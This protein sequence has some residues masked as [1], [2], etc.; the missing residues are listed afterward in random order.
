M[1]ITIRQANISDIN[2]LIAL[3][4]EL[5]EIEED[6]IFD[7]EKQRRGVEL[8]LASDN[9]YIIVAEHDSEVIA[10]CTVL[11][12]ISTAEG[13]HVG[14]IEDMVVQ[15][16]YACKGIGRQLLSA[17]ELRAKEQGLTR[18]QLLADRNNQHALTFYNKMD[19]QKTQLIGLRKFI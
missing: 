4:K 11:T 3:L 5:F 19:W 7:E 12:I 6:F 13:G 1:D 8:L 15:K 14:L 2:F 10:M 18:L 9:D 17:V 16:A